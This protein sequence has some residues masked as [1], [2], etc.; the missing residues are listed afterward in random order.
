[1][2]PAFGPITDE[3]RRRNLEETDTRVA[4]TMIFGVDGLSTGAYYPRWYGG[5]LAPA[6]PPKLR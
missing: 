4:P 1:M 5:F 2:L 6:P 3:Q